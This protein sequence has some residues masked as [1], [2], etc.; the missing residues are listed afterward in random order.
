MTDNEIYYGSPAKP[1]EATPLNAGPLSLIYQDG[2]LRSIKYGGVEI[3]KRV[4]FALR[5]QFWNTIPGAIDSLKINS[6]D[7]NFSITFTSQYSSGDILL[8]CESEINGT[9]EGKIEFSFKAVALSTFQRNRIGFCV[10][11]PIDLCAGALCSVTCVDG[12][13][14]E[15]TFPRFI[16]PFQPFKNIRTLEYNIDALSSVEIC[17]EGDTF[18]ME[19]QRNWT[20][21]SFKTYCTPLSEPMPVAVQTGTLIEQKIILS[22]KNANSHPVIKVPEY[23]TLQIPETFA[24]SKVVP[25]IGTMIDTP[26]SPVVIEKAELLPFS[27]LR[28]DIH[29][30]SESIISD[31]ENMSGIS[32]LLEIPAELVLYFSSDIENE[33]LYIYQLL[34]TSQIPVTRFLIFKE[35]EI[36]TSA[37]TLLM[38]VPVLK[39]YAPKAL[40]AAGS[41]NYF[42]DLNRNHPPSELLDQICYSANPQVHTFDNVS[43]ME[44]LPGIAETLQSASLF[45]GNAQPVISPMTL[46]PRK[47]SSKPQKSGGPDDR[48]KG[49]FCSA[50]SVANLMYCI[51]GG[52][53]SITYY[54]LSGDSGMMDEDGLRV[55]PVFHILSSAAGKA[56]TNAEACACSEPSKIASIAFAGG[57]QLLLQV[58]NLTDKLQ[59]VKISNLPSTIY[60]KFIDETTFSEVTNFPELWHCTKGIHMNIDEQV[61]MFELLPY[62]VLQIE[63]SL[64]R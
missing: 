62:A 64:V 51:E 38:V 20:D 27:H 40:I 44:N 25:G 16:E 63:S 6:S 34:A 60:C 29:L 47:N 46:R 5:D 4:Y 3:I 10:L 58:A 39:T 12:S 50:W 24:L 57:M 53:S 54:S 42:A 55:Y 18:E 43:V 37:K 48:Q 59:K 36:V 19:D 35:D 45:F 13:N 21:N 7:D 52:A 33:L 31:M 49:L 9:S 41:N 28:F 56:G 17:F 23:I 14:C 11:H 15:K 32:R 30:A 2:F 61:Q 1:P 22:V 8:S 26:L